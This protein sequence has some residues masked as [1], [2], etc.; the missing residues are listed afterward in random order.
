MSCLCDWG[1]MKS[2]RAYA[3]LAPALPNWGLEVCAARDTVLMGSV[4]RDRQH[5]SD[6]VPSAEETPLRHRAQ[7]LLAGRSKETQEDSV[8]RR[9]HQKQELWFLC[10][11]MDRG[12]KISKQPTLIYLGGS[13]KATASCG[14]VV[15]SFWRLVFVICYCSVPCVGSFLLKFLR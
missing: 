12:G 3:S 8:K 9:C 14:Y 10:W 7:P 13:S 2:S 6:A 4:P 5:V 11:K 1:R 15:K